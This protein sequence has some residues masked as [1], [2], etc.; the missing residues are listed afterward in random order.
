M[1]A[2]QRDGRCPAPGRGRHRPPS[3]GPSRPSSSATTGYGSNSVSSRIDPPVGQHLARPAA[4]APGRPCRRR[5]SANV[6]SS[7]RLDAPA[8]SA[9]IATSSRRW[10]CLVR[11][12][13]AAS[14]RSEVVSRL[15]IDVGDQA[16]HLVRRRALA[17]RS[18]SVR[19]GVVAWQRR[20]LRLRPLTSAAVRWMCRSG[21]GSTLRPRGH[22]DVDDAAV[23]RASPAGTPRSDG[24]APHPRPRTAPPRRTTPRAATGPLNGA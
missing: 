22:G 24:S 21:C 9:R 19:S 7:D 6:S 17:T 11:R 23:R 20:R 4:V 15:R 12:I 13:A 1:P 16:G 18:S 3:S 10:R 8:A 2:A 5:T 14:T